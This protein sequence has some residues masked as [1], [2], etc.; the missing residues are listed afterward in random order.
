MRIESQRSGERVFSVTPTAKCKVGD[1]DL[2]GTPRIAWI[3]FCCPV[4]FSERALPFTTTTIYRSS[5]FVAKRT[6]RLGFENPVEFLQSSIVITRA[7]VI[8][9]H[10]R[11]ICIP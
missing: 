8:K 7:P 4:K 1:A 11:L 3:Q 10:P 9:H 2:G 6:V 5:G